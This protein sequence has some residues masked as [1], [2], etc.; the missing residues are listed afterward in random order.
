M[1]KIDMES[2]TAHVWYREDLDNCHGGA[3]FLEGKLFGCGCRL[4]GKNF[5][6]VDFLTGKTGRSTARSAKLES[7]P[8]T[9]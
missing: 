4:G 6:C 8:P 9:E 7:P 5:Y 2:H 3:I 1:L